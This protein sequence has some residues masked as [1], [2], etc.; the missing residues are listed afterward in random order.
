MYALAAV[1][2]CPVLSPTSM[3]SELDAKLTVVILGPEEAATIMGSNV[4][5]AR[6]HTCSHAARRA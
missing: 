5:W 4:L 6:S 3:D 1:L 2:T